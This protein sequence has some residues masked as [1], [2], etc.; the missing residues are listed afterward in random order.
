MSPVSY[1]EYNSLLI[2][3]AAE[4]LAGQII[5]TIKNSGEF[6]FCY[7]YKYRVKSSD[8]LLEK[9]KRKKEQK[10]NYTILDITDVVGIR[11]LTLFRR[12]MPVVA[13][14][15]IDLIQHVSSVSPNAFQKGRIDEILIYTVNP[16]NDSLVNQVRLV[17]ERKLHGRDITRPTQ[18]SKYSSIHLVTGGGGCVSGLK[19]VDAGISYAIPIE[20][21]IRTVFEDAWGEVDHK[22]GY[23]INSKKSSAPNISN[24]T[25]VLAHLRSLKRFTDACAEYADLIHAEANGDLDV[26]VGGIK[27]VGSK[28]NVVDFLVEKSVNPALIEKYSGCRD[29]REEAYREEGGLEAKTLLMR[30]AECFHNSSKEYKDFDSTSEEGVFY[31]FSQ[32]GKAFCLMATLEPASISLANEVYDDLA[33]KYPASPMLMARLGFSQGKLGAIDDSISSYEKALK[34]IR[35]AAD[36]VDSIFLLDPD[37]EY[38]QTTVPKLLGYQLWE[39]SEQSEQKEDRVDLLV[40]AFESTNILSDVD[41]SDPERKHIMNNIIYY[42]LCLIKLLDKSEHEKYIAVIRENIDE[43]Q[44]ISRREGANNIGHLDTLMKALVQVNRIDD[45]KSVADQ[46]MSV[47]HSGNSKDSLDAKMLMEIAHEAYMVQQN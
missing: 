19:G 25:S 22:Y 40:R 15:I 8:K 30:A 3:R 5:E 39:K 47:I 17:T 2:S 7:A 24:A 32:M 41:V 10:E 27:P 18:T 11:F 38:V 12:E 46:L 29:I 44:A 14:K 36:D 26:K 9:L 31:Y 45:A 6:D 34:L 13:E 20:V 28:Q 37:R 43:F 4:K 16:L 1:D 33:K 23:S 42:S 21:Q 35:E